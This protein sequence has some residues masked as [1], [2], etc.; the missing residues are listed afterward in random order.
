MQVLQEYL[1]YPISENDILDVCDKTE[2]M[3]LVDFVK[4]NLIKFWKW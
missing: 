3:R 1:R 4:R 2:D